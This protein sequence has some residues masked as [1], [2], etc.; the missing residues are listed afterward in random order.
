MKEYG[1]W[2][3]AWQRFKHKTLADLRS[4]WPGILILILG[5]MP[6]RA[7]KVEAPMGTGPSFE[8]PA[9]AAAFIATQRECADAGGLT[10]EERE[11]YLKAPAFSVAELLWIWWPGA[12]VERNG[13]A[14]ECILMRRG[15]WGLYEWDGY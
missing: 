11:D 3:R 4:A 9:E 1:I 8:T 2:L 6:R 5:S 7:W 14:I 10:E 13:W 12:R 15:E